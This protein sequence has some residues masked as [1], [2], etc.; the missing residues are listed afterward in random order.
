M[1]QNVLLVT[2]LLVRVGLGE[3][4]NQQTRHG[5]TFVSSQRTE[6]HG[7]HG[8]SDGLVTGRIE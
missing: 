5:Y 1:T 6:K 8:R 2:A 3:T 4:L 7:R